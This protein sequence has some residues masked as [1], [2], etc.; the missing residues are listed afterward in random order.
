MPSYKDD[1]TGTWYCKFYYEDWTG[2]KRQKKKRGFKLKREADDWEREFLIKEA[3]SPDMTFG[4]LCELYLAD[5]K[6]NLRASTYVMRKSSVESK[7]LPFLKDKVAKDITPADIRLWQN[8]IKKMTRPDG[9]PYSQTFLRSLNQQLSTLFNWGIKFCRLPSNP[10]H[11]AG[12][13]GKKK[14]GEMQILTVD[15][16]NAAMEYENNWAKRLAFQIMFWSGIRVGECL[17]LTP[18]DVLPSKELRI[19]K[20]YHR[21]EGEDIAGPPKTETSYRL[22]PIPD[23]LYGEIQRYMKAIYGIEP[24]DRIFYF[25]KS[26]LNKALRS[27]TQKAGVPDIR[28]HDLRHSH[29]ALL[30]EMGCSIVLVA[31]R[32]GDSVKT[33]METY[34]HLYPSKQE[35]IA[36]RLNDLQRGFAGGGPTLEP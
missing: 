16:F 30:V 3:R 13:M 19:E 35:D 1:N 17:A 6:Q 23:F 24:D 27:D 2:K 22:A 8:E 33:V 9:Q 11:I 31:E 7:F 34:S 21:K 12:S 25:T 26:T 32:L 10:V 28:V 18:E 14:A 29:A 15:Q 5:A 20:T 4:S 36:R